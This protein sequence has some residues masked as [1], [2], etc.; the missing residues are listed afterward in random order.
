M[1]GDKKLSAAGICSALLMVL[2][3]GWLT[4]STP[5]I[6]AAQQQY[7]LSSMVD[8]E[9]TQTEELPFSNN[10]E[11][12]SENSTSNISEYLH[13]MHHNDRPSSLFVKFYKCHPSELYFAFHPELISPP[14]ELR[15]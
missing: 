6:Y 8:L 11:E 4:I 10:T 14:P 9:E 1:K 3:L 12:R 13:E 5:F 15:A 2:A 7:C